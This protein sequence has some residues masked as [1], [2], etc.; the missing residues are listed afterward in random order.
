MIIN[1]INDLD[2]I[3]M[4]SQSLVVVI[5]GNTS[6]MVSLNKVLIIIIDNH[7]NNGTEAILTSYVDNEYYSKSVRLN[8]DLSN[9]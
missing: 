6:D 4:V 5:I 2:V 3:L 7:C 1:N 9:D 8:N